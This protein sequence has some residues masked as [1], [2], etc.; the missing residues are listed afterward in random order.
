[1]DI[2]LRHLAHVD[3]RLGQFISQTGALP[4][5]Q[6]EDPE[7]YQALILSVSHQQV[8]AKAADAILGRLK[9][10][11][12]GTIPPPATLLSLPETELRSHGFSASKA[13]ALH[14]IAAKTLDGTIPSR[15]QALALADEELIKRLTVT[16][17]VGRWTVEMLLI[18]ALNRP[19]VFPVDDFGVREGY[20]L[21]HG[22]DAQP[23]PRD[24]R[25]ISQPYSPY[26]TIAAL[27]CWHAAN[28]A[29]RAHGQRP[30]APKTKNHRPLVAGET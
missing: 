18:F 21:I 26:G 9:S 28:E 15:A 14:D 13:A 20:R 24:L 11:Y 22:L 23:K 2:A 8:H 27:Y 17:G 4:P 30:R 12:R 6:Y 1:M 29:K 7:P 3:P 10:A 25:K 16:R 19:D 5:R